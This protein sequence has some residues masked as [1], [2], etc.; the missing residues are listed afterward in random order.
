MESVAQSAAEVFSS[1]R[2][3]DRSHVKL[4]GTGLPH[5]NSMFL[6]VWQKLQLGSAGHYLPLS[7]L[8]FL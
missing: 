1:T 7:S 8:S 3:L 5:F 6:L 2:M 4:Q